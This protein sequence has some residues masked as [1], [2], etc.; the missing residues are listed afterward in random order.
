MNYLSSNV[1]KMEVACFHSFITVHPILVSFF[2]VYHKKMG[3]GWSGERMQFYESFLLYG[4]HLTYVWP[5]FD[6]QA[7]HIIC[8]QSIGN[9]P[10]LT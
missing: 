8:P 6:C 10:N 3:I 5:T 7:I 2:L 1:R 4:F 9:T